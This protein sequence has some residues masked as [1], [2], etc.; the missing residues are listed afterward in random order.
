MKNILYLLLILVSLA[1]SKIT[2]YGDS[3]VKKW[4]MEVSKISIT[5]DYKN[6]KFTSLNMVLDVKNIVSGSSSMDHHAQE[7]MKYDKYK[8][9]YFKMVSIDTSKKIIKGKLT[10]CNVTRDIVLKPEVLKKDEIKGTYVL[11]MKDYKITPP[12]AM[13]GAIRSYSK[14]KI[15]YDV[16]PSK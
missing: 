5:N 15:V 2:I 7:A 9:I 16:N 6:D 10:I 1:Y 14:I 13:F 3:N 12:T 8:F 4:N 11:D